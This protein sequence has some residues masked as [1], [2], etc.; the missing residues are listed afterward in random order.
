[1]WPSLAIIILTGALVLHL[2]WYRRFL[3]AQRRCAALDS[4]L[5][6]LRVLQTGAATGAEA[7]RSALFNSMVEGVLVADSN[8][9]ILFVNDAL[10]E[11]IN[12][13]VDPVGRTIIEALRMHEIDSLAERVMTESRISGFELE[14]QGTH[15]GFFEVNAAAVRDLNGANHGVILVF[16]DLTRVRNL[17]NTR[18]DF[19]ANVSHELRTPLALIKGCVE[20]LLDGAREDPK[21]CSRFLEII[22]KHSDRLEFLINDLLTI[23]ELES[24]RAPMHFGPVELRPLFEQV[25]EEIRAKADTKGVRL[26]IELASDL[27]VK[28]DVDR[29]RQVLVNL[30]DNA[31]KYGPTGGLT[32]V[33]ARGIDD[34]TVEVRVIDDGPGIPPDAAERVFERFFRLDQARTRELGGTGLGLSIVKHI[35][36]SHSGRVWVEPATSRGSEFCFTLPKAPAESDSSPRSGE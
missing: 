16:H 13:S 5:A 30:L 17:E 35:V 3:Q 6:G 34:T 22:L 14:L 12:L 24:G 2:W 36:Q 33:C 26:Q 32:W 29:L 8:G 4:E 10:R 18:R 25:C 15:P 7:E 21:A 31:I 9:R 19:V 27:T 11:M 28:A 1:M 20:T 23:S